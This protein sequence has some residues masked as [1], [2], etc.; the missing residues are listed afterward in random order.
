M[1]RI[2]CIVLG[3]LVLLVSCCANADS[4]ADKERQDKILKID[5]WYSSV[6]QNPSEKFRESAGAIAMQSTLQLGSGSKDWGPNNP[7][8]KALYDQVNNDVQEEIEQ[9]FSKRGSEIETLFKTR[10]ADAL[11]ME[12]VDGLT[13]FYKSNIGNRYWELSN[14]VAGMIADTTLH[15]NDFATMK[16]KSQPTDEELKSWQRFTAVSSI[17]QIMTGLFE[18]DKLAGR[19]TSGASAIGFIFGMAMVSH[20]DEF[21]K[22][23]TTYEN[24]LADFTEFIESPVGKHLV[25]AQLTTANDLQ[26]KIN[27]ITLELMNH[28]NEHQNSWKQMYSQIVGNNA[29][30][31]QQQTTKQQASNNE[32][33]FHGKDMSNGT[34]PKMEVLESDDCSKNSPVVATMHCHADSLVNAKTASVGRIVVNCNDPKFEDV[35]ICATTNLVRSDRDL[36]SAFKWL[37]GNLSPAEVM[38]LRSDQNAWIKERNNVCKLSSDDTHGEKWLSKILKNPTKSTCVMRYSEARVVE[39]NSMIEKQKSLTSIAQHPPGDY[40]HYSE[41]THEHGLWYFEV[42]VNAGEISQATPVDI[43][44]SCKPSNPDDYLPSIG[45]HTNYKPMVNVTGENLI[46]LAIDLNKGK[47]YSSM[48]G[49]WQHGMPG[50]SEGLDISLGRPWRCG[51]QSNEPVENLLKRKFIQVNFGDKP[52]VYAPPPEYKPYKGGPIWLPSGSYDALDYASIN[53]KSDKPTVSYK[54]G[55]KNW[56]SIESSNLKYKAIFINMEIDCSTLKS[57]DV[58]SIFVTDS[59][60]YVANSSEPLLIDD[61]LKKPMFMSICFLHEHHLN[62]PDI[63]IEDHWEPM[64]SPYPEIKIYEA[65]DKREFNQGFLLIKQKIEMGTGIIANGEISSTVVQV[66]AFS[67]NDHTAHALIATPY[68]D[69]GNIL[70]A[71]YYSVSDTSPKLPENRKRFEDICKAYAENST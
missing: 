16:P 12:D 45:F 22:I 36:N 42:L 31:V 37:V 30:P 5:S 49:I 24:D 19:D 14:D 33:N 17:A 32:N 55:L 63:S 50:S 29:N 2:V 64:L 4:N 43:T 23:A 65:I 27:E 35:S 39:L 41:V 47:L 15:M 52:F 62:L 66:T 34:Q 18:K 26:P 9:F 68:G 54:K 67:C 3:C 59:N 13:T 58:G 53:L 8:W 51:I 20:Q 21:R 70:D 56:T 1:K 7:N 46:G 38:K 69:H 57:R 44:W 40:I 28:V 11:S 71:S 25:E 6:V 61:E 10:F 60:T 48:N